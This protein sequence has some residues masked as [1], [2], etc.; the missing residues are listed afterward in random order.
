MVS[1]PKIRGRFA[2]TTSQSPSRRQRGTTRPR[3]ESLDGR[4]LLC[5]GGCKQHA[6]LLD[7]TIKPSALTTPAEVAHL[8]HRNPD[9][10]FHPG[11]GHASHVMADLVVHHHH[12]VAGCGCTSATPD[13]LVPA[14]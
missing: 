4:F 6:S 11:N 2:Q 10:P 7:Q 1:F 5:P 13:L 3:L 14:L 12:A 9:S 8:S